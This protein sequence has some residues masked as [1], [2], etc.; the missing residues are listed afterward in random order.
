MAI[1][2]VGGDLA[3]EIIIEFRRGERARGRPHTITQAVRLDEL[4]DFVEIFPVSL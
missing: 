3:D 4:L 1:V 2:R